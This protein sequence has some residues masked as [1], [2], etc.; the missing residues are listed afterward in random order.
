MTEQR[1]RATEAKEMNDEVERAAALNPGEVFMAAT[2]S[3]LCPKTL[4]MLN[5]ID[6]LKYETESTEGALVFGML[7]GRSGSSEAGNMVM[8]FCGLVNRQ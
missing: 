8:M 1:G 4:G 7:S 3:I 5:R 2:A 6:L